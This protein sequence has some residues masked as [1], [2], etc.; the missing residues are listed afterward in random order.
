[1]EGHTSQ[2]AHAPCFILIH[3]RLVPYNDLHRVIVRAVS[4]DTIS[5]MLKEV[6][7]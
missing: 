4:G 5:V 7:H 6:M 1:M 3:M 2:A